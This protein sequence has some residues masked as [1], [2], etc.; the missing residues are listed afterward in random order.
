[1]ATEQWSD[2]IRNGWIAFIE[3]TL[4]T[5]PKIELR[6]GAGPANVAASDTGSLL[7]TCTAASDWLAAPS[8]GSA[9]VIGTFSGTATGGVVGHYRLKTSG[10]TAHSQG[11]VTQAFVL[12]TTASTPINS[13]LVTVASTAALS[14]G[15]AVSGTGVPDGATVAEITS[16]TTF[17]LNLISTAGI[18]NGAAI[19]IGDTSGKLWLPNTTLT[20]SQSVTLT[21]TF[22]APGA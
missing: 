12:T 4:G 13:N 1:M 10:G 3:S 8:G 22:T 17:K 6:T 19:Y 9:A 20:T 2:T 5:T 11:L 21:R 14:L 7:C 16:G 15:Q 18:A